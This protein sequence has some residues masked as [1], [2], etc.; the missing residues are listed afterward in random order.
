M[1]KQKSRPAEQLFEIW[2]VWVVEIFVRSAHA[3]NHA[4]HGRD[5]PTHTRCGPYVY[6]I[7]DI[8]SWKYIP[9]FVN[10]HTIQPSNQTVKQIKFHCHGLVETMQKFCYGFNVV[11]IV[12]VVVCIVLVLKGLF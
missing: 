11:A 8:I 6:Y 12:I 5:T 7:T 3:N 10:K 4:E 2:H 1:S 9:S